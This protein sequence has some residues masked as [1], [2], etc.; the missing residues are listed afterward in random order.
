MAD[1][2]VA[3]DAAA[4]EAPVANY[5]AT[6]A[7]R[8]SAMIAETPDAQEEAVEG[9]EE[10]APAEKEAAPAAAAKAEPEKPAAEQT[11]AEKD[12]RRKLREMRKER[13]TEKGARER[14]EAEARE[15]QTA[16]ARLSKLETELADARAYQTRHRELLEAGK[17]DEAIKLAGAQGIDSFEALQ[18]RVIAAYK[19]ASPGDPRV[20]EL[21][22]ELEALKKAREEELASRTAEEQA[23]VE[24]ERDRRMFE[25]AQ[26]AAEEHDDVVIRRF[27]KVPGFIHN[28]AATAK[29]AGETHNEDQILEVV[30]RGFADLEMSFLKSHGFTEAQIQNILSGNVPGDEKTEESPVRSRAKTAPAKAGEPSQRKPVVTIP[31][32]TAESS[33]VKPKWD[34]K[35]RRE[36]WEKARIG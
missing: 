4:D 36:L 24:A 2:A 10:G 11:Q 32:N 31:T 26:E 15:A 23:Q 8:W 12:S 19:D 9:D 13:Y 25:A 22:S 17:F 27:A 20:D 34:P 14:A 29:T 33:H 35:S 3:P 6:R 1:E 30:K 16:G 28:I 21:K 5:E 18:K 7:A